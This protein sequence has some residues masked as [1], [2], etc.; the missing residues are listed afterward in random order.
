MMATAAQ[1]NDAAEVPR[2]LRWRWNAGQRSQWLFD[3]VNQ[4]V[5][6]FAPVIIGH[7]QPVGARPPMERSRSSLQDLGISG[8]FGGRGLPR[9]QCRGLI[10]ARRSR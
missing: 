3:K 6:V 8:E 10:E 2:V 9:Q 5:A 4:G 7:R 1:R